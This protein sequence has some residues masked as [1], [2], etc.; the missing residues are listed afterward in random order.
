VIV[1]E[2]V[3]VDVGLKIMGTDRMI[4]ARYATLDQRPEALD[5][6]RVDFATNILLGVVLDSQ[7]RVSQPRHV[8]VAGELICKKNRL[9]VNGSGHKRDKRVPLDIGDDLSHHLAVPFHSADYLCLAL[10]PT[11]TLASSHSTDIGLVNL[12]L[13]A[14]LAVI[15]VKQ[16]AYLREHSPSR[17]VGDSC[18]TLDLLGGN[19]ASG[20]RH[21]EYG[22]EP[23]SERGL[24]LVEYRVGCGGHLSP[25]EVAGIDLAPRYAVVR[26]H[27]LALLAVYAV[28][29]ANV[30]DMLKTGVLIGE[31]LVKVLYGIALHFLAPSFVLTLLLYH[32]ISVMS[33]D[34]YQK[35]ILSPEF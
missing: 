25:A 9:A 11:T 31:L 18:F 26:G 19:P 14:E 2:S 30:L 8:V 32:K 21:N 1:A 15:L 6:V 22:V 35:E 33:R 4:N 3:F 34:N 5:A 12:Y 13:T 27:F 23:G 10:C 17:L 24:G 7:V 20:G 28:W 29:K 16:F